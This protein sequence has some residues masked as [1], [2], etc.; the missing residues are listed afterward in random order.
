MMD[1]YER[2]P[3]KSEID[4]SKFDYNLVPPHLEGRVKAFRNL[5]IGE[6]WN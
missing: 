2:G 6:R 3:E 1:A 4:E 5:S